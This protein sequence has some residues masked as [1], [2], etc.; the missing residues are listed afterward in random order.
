MLGSTMS[1]LG[2]EWAGWRCAFSAKGKLLT[3][4][5][6]RYCSDTMIEWGQVPAGFEELSTE[7]WDA[8]SAELLRRTVR[9]L[10]E[11]GCNAENLGATISR[12]ELTCTA[13]VPHAIDV[14]TEGYWQCE[15]VFD[16]IGGVRPLERSGALPALA[17]RTRVM[18]S[19][20]PASGLLSPAQPVVV[21]HERQW[22]AD[23]E[24]E[25]REAGIGSRCGIDAAW[26]ST[27]VGLACFADGKEARSLCGATDPP[28]E[29]GFALRLAGGVE[30]RGSAGVLSVSVDDGD[31]GRVC[32]QRSAFDS[33]LGACLSEA[34]GAG[35]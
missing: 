26:L 28:H 33:G 20:D 10:P 6:E 27:A 14:A 17:E 3:G 12:A 18:C 35:K 8:E 25:V 30:I 19:F 29:E 1:R 16:G 22:S 4:D 31:G 2:G 11:D 13:T 5:I 21:C 9:L 7:S 15:S 24:L 23:T 32:L 34:V